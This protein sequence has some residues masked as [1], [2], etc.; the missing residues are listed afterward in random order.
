M[1]KNF[2]FQLAIEILEQTRTIQLM[3]AES[4]FEKSYESNQEKLYPSI[5]KVFC[6]KLFHY[7]WSA[8]GF[9]SPVDYLCTVSRWVSTFFYCWL[10][11]SILF[12]AHIRLIMPADLWA[13]D[14]RGWT[15]TLISIP[16]SV[17]SMFTGGVYFFGFAAMVAGAHFV[18]AGTVSSENMFTWELFI[19]VIAFSLCLRCSNTRSLGIKDIFYLA[20]MEVEIY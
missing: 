11:Y 10:V 2:E 8:T 3:V 5:R 15:K 12:E 13:I 17:N 18:H 1:V 9:A 20:D 16:I 7:N 19:L 6:S 4:Y 14:K